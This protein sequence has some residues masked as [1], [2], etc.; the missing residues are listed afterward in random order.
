MA[1]KARA[2]AKAK[3]RGHGGESG[4][5]DA[6]EDVV[7]RI[8]ATLSTAISSGA[9]KPGSKILDD[10]IAEHFGVSRTVVRGALDV[11]QRDHLLERKRNRGAFVAEPSVE[12]ARQLFAARHGLEHVILGLVVEHAS[13]DGLDR[14]EALNEEEAHLPENTGE[15]RD[16]PTPQ[17]H[18]ELA[19]LGKNEVL[20][21]VLVKVLA[22]VSLVNA[23]YEVEPRDNCGDHRNIIAAIRRRD[24]ATARALME[25]HLVDLEERVRLT[26]NDGDKNSF[27]NVLQTFSA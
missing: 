4:R 18:V 7:D 24:L 17:F 11:L 5:G 23:L 8:C 12:E 22:R 26:P 9:L 1:R 2:P 6:G 20:T 16:G 19:R 21:E 3:T 15:G 10:V 27:I 14:L 13:E 25:A